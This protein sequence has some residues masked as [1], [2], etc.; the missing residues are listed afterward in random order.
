M[1]EKQGQ[2][3]KW[4]VNDCCLFAC[5]WLAIR[6]CR[7][8]AED[9]RGYRSALAGWRIVKKL[10][11]VLQIARERCAAMGWP[12]ISPMLATH[13]DIVASDAAH[14]SA[15]GVCA[16]HVALFAGEQG[17]VTRKITQCTHAWRIN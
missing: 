13:G 5:D 8:L 12:E 7:D 1:L 14:G 16:G 11:G 15:L 17:I 6:S 3:F 4:G 2:P 10:G 9:L